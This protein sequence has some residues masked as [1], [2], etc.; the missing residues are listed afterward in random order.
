[1][2]DNSFEE[3]LE[4]L[5]KFGDSIKK[6]MKTWYDFNTRTVRIRSKTKKPVGILSLIIIT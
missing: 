6:P 4:K 1:M 3:C 5:V 2:Y